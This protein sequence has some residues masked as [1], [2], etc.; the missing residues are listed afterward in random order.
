M[1]NHPWYSAAGVGFDWD[2]L[3][4]Q[5]MVPPWKPKVKNVEDASNF[6]EVEIY[7]EHLTELKY[8]KNNDPKSGWDDHF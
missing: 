6:G 5:T 3:E 7:E 4:N 2:K 1:K 8:K